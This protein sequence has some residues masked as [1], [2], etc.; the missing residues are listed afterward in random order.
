MFV[1]LLK[2]S[3]SSGLFGPV[4]LQVMQAKSEDGTRCIQDVGSN[5]VH[6]ASI[7]F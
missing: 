7:D 5:S 6:F 2:S 4:K 3:A 1:V